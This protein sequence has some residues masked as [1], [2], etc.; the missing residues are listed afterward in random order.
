MRVGA[1]LSG[2]VVLAACGGDAPST[3]DPG[4]PGAERAASLWWMMLGLAGAVVLLVVVLLARALTRRRDPD[5]DPDDSGSVDGGAGDRLAPIERRFVLG[6]GVVLPLAVLVTLAVFAVDAIDAVESEAGDVE[7]EVVGHQYWWEIRYPGTRVVTANELHIPAGEPV[8]LRLTS[9]DV[10]H[11]FW[12]PELAG[13]KD[14]VPGRE[15]TLVIEADRPGT[16]Y[17]QCAEF[18]GIQHA[19]M[20]TLV[21]AHPRDEYE[22]WL[23]GQARDAEEPTTAQEERGLEVFESGACAGCHTIR[24]TEAGGELGPDLTHL[25][26]RRT[27]GAGVLDNTRDNLASWILDAQAHKPGSLMP[28]VDLDGRDAGAVVAYLESL[29]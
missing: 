14:L 21:V 28:P 12:I 4:G 17:G 13:K 24:G 22:A 25:A 16:Y 3:L 10:I 27:L 11:S 29:E 6:G 1:A 23:A 8:T 26:G 20:A 19:N 15:N 9:E 7:V 5:P 18:C 2:L